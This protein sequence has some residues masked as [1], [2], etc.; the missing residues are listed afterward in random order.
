MA[1]GGLQVR[2][3]PVK[4]SE[5]SIMKAWPNEKKNGTGLYRSRF[6]RILIAYMALMFLSL[7]TKPA[8]AA[9]EDEV[10]ATFNRFVAAQNAHDIKAVESLLLSSP[11]FLWIT[12]GTPI[13]GHDA[14][15]KRF[16]AL[17]DGTW[18]L[19]PETSGLKITMVSEG[20]AQIYV[21]IIFTIG[22]AGQAAQQTKF[23]MNQVL[24]KTSDGWR[25]S[26]ILPIPAPPQ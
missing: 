26:S 20:V 23:L 15:L 12:R 3:K 8:I 7:A 11:N 4:P 16:T 10:R 21:P 24:V 13:W 6:A 2:K 5:E 22:A 19:D 18:R 17:Y 9:A 14:A 25:V 1:I